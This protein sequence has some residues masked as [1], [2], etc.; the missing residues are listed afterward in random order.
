MAGAEPV[1]GTPAG[2]PVAEIVAAVAYR[3]LP[4]WRVTDDG[5]SQGHLLVR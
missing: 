1:A 5:N 3:L 2:N 4:H